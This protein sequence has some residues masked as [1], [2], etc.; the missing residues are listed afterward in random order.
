MR[1]EADFEMS[2][3]IVRGFR[4]RCFGIRQIQDEMSMYVTVM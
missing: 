4:L 2:M 3:W 1:I